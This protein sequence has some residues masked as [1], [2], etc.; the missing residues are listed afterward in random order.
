MKWYISVLQDK[1]SAL[2]LNNVTKCLSGIGVINFLNNCLVFSICYFWLCKNWYLQN[3]CLIKKWIMLEIVDKSVF[4]I[5]S[6]PHSSVFIFSFEGHNLV[7]CSLHMIREICFLL[8][9]DLWK[10]QL[11]L[12]NM[13]HESLNLTLAKNFFF[14]NPFCIAW[15]T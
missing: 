5:M 7:F 12:W 6:L 11:E 13:N 9:F 1:L 8:N 2:V 10:L 4:K 3:F 15:T 14:W